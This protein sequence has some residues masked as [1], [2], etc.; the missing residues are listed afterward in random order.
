[1]RSTQD[2]LAELRR[3][4]EQICDNTVSPS[5]RAAYV[6]SYCRF[7]SWVHQNHPN[8]IPVAFAD[9]VGVTEGLSEA[10]IRRR[11]KPLLTRKHDDPPLTFGNLDPEVFET[12]LLTLRKADGS[13]LSYSAFNTHRA[14]LFNIYRDYVQ[15]MGPAMEKELKQFFKGLKLQL[16][17]AQACGEGQVKVGERPSII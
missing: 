4:A 3:Q 13:M 8:F 1:M 6:N 11:I 12:W 16:A 5:S 2:A 7:V 15:Q 9:R 17:T 14:G 10:Q